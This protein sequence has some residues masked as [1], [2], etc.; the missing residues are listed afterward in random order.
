M[1]YYY[2]Y[3]YATDGVVDNTQPCARNARARRARGIS[4][5]P[6]RSGRIYMGIAYVFARG[7]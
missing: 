3:Y 6:A 4:S 1:Y 7:R 2:Y 5:L